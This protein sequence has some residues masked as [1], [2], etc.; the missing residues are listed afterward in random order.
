MPRIF[1]LFIL[2]ATAAC[3]QATPTAVLSTEPLG[4]AKKTGEFAN[5]NVQPQGQTAQITDQES[6]QA[7]AELR[8]AGQR[9]AARKQSVEAQSN[10]AAEVQRLRRLALAEQKRRLAEIAATNRQN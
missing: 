2:F 4:E 5:I 7:K 6:E 8:A 10:S 3:T 1:A 9:S